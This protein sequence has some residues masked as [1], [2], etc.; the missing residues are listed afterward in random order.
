MFKL[1]LLSDTFSGAARHFL[2]AY[3]RKIVH[4]Q[5]RLRTRAAITF[6]YITQVA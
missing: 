4:F 3:F 5:C 6:V 1:N 2:L